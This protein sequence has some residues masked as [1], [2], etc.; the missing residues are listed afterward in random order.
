VSVDLGRIRAVARKEFR[1]YR[2]NRFIVVTMLVLPVIF[3]ALPVAALFRLSATTAHAVIDKQV[4]ST[5]LTTFIIPVVVPAT[6]AAYSVVGE[7]DQGTLEPLLT[8]PVRRD[9]LLLGKALAAIVPSVLMGYLFFA[10]LVV[11]VRI[12]ATQHVVDVV[13]QPPQF[14]A[15]ALFSPLL[16]AWSIW[17]GI[18]ISARSSDVRVAQQLST[19]ASLPALA[20]TALFSFQVLSP[21][22]TLA[23]V[24]ALA[25]AVV[26]V[27]AWRVV[28][29]TFDRERLIT[30]HRATDAPSRRP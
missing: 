14:L 11:S 18:A 30:G 5:L 13:W 9:E 26:D 1:E 4:G 24:L 8:T 22:V 12:G 25:L 27:V 10:V 19:L 6:I 20:V 29:A 2:R 15:Q 23:V 17:V 28:S 16:A 3:L 7:R 21:T